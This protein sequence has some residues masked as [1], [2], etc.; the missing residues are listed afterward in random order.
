M[1]GE[2]KSVTVLQVIEELVPFRQV[3]M[4]CDRWMNT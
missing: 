1:G 2:K 3:E 4:S